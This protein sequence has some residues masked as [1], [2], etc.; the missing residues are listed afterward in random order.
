[1][2]NQ[3]I[4]KS[5]ITYSGIEAG[6]FL[7]LEKYFNTLSNRNAPK[8]RIFVACAHLGMKMTVKERRDASEV[9]LKYEKRQSE[10]SNKTYNVPRTIL[11]NHEHEMKSLLFQ[12]S[13]ME[14]IDNLDVGELQ[15]IWNN[16]DFRRNGS[17]YGKTMYENALNGAKYLLLLFEIDE[18]N[19]NQVN[20]EVIKILSR[21]VDDITLKMLT[22]SAASE[23]EINSDLLTA[24][25]IEV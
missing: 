9:E 11:Q 18:L 21:E 13:V 6:Y 12:I 10:Y 24:E 7:S 1:M 3:S 14:N 25:T 22:N 23:Y 2:E 19:A 17:A 16:P 8:Y 4:F 20:E 5:N 15:N